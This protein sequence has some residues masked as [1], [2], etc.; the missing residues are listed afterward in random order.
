MVDL[1]LPMTDGRTVIL[2]R[3]TEP[4]PDQAL[5]LQMLNSVCPANSHLGSP[6]IEL[7]YR[8]DIRSCGADL[9]TSPHRKP[10]YFGILGRELRKFG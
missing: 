4:E 1:H 6:Q 7:R 9:A 10:T 2:S 3:F 5:L 8:N